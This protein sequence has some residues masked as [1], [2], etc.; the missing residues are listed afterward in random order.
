LLA[1]EAGNEHLLSPLC[2]L[3]VVF[4][5]GVEELNEFLVALGFGILDIGLK[6]LYVI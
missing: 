5:H 6:R 1:L 3:Q 4:Q 2:R